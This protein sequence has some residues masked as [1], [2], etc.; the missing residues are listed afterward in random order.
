MLFLVFAPYR[1]RIFGGLCRLRLHGN[2][3]QRDLGRGQQ[4]TVDAPL[5]L[6]RAFGQLRLL[7]LSE[8]PRPADRVRHQGYAFF[9]LGDV[10]ARFLVVF[11]HL[12]Q[13]LLELGVQHTADVDVDHV[14]RQRFRYP[15]HHRGR[16]PVHDLFAVEVAGEALGDDRARQPPQQHADAAEPEPADDAD[17]DLAVLRPKV[18]D[19]LHKVHSCLLM[20]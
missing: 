6:A 7:F 9:H 16:Y 5:Q 13:L 17:D 12:P 10:F 4:C 2:G 3:L 19:D 15:V 8:Q 11:D 20:C 1:D 14:P 18:L